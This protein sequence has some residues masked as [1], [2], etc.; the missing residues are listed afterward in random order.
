MFYVEYNIWC[1]KLYGSKCSSDSRRKIQH[2][3]YI[4]F[5]CPSWAKIYNLKHLLQKLRWLVMIDS[6]AIFITDY[7]DKMNINISSHF[8][9]QSNMFL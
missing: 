5:R 3:A 4:L 1:T 2:K 6:N 9:S 7:S 8:I